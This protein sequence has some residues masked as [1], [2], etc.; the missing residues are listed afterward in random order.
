MIRIPV[1][2]ITTI[3]AFAIAAPA[4]ADRP[5][6]AD[7]RAAIED[8]LRANGFTSWEE[9]EL[10]DDGPYWEVD[11]ARTANRRDGKFDLKIDPQTMKI[12]KRER[13]D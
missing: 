13:D 4:L 5:P 9:I 10:D 7:E 11:D 2:A 8:V 3:A 12:I 1:T 6:T